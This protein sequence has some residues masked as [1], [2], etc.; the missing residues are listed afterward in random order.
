MQTPVS[1]DSPRVDPT[2][3][4]DLRL[5]ALRRFAIAITVLN[6]LG[7]T[8]LGFETSLAQ[9][10]VA[11]GTAYLVEVLLE[12]VAARSEGRKPAFIDKPVAVVDFF[13]P[14]HITGLAISMLLYAGD[15][16][17]PYVFASTIAITSKTLLTAPIGKRS[18]H[19]LNPSNA[20]LVATIFLFPSVAITPGYHFSEYITGPWDWALPGLIICTGTFLNWRFTR[21]IPLI[22]SWLAAFV[23]QAWVRHMV[24]DTWIWAS[25]APLTGVAYVLFTFYMVPDPGTTPSTTRGQIAFGASVGLLYGVFM[26]MHVVFGVFVALFVVCFTRGLALHALALPRVVAWRAPMAAPVP[27]IARAPQQSGPSMGV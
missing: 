5:P 15:R 4:R 14:A 2:V 21:K 16:S 25:L 8:V 9:V 6:T 23:F 26:A 11:A 20:G 1:L 22:L 24:F 12:L 17:L 3:R 27:A 13:L 19:F 7:H 10:V 18:R